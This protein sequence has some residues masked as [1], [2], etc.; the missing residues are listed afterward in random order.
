MDVERGVS[1]I[2]QQWCFDVRLAGTFWKER[3]A[4]LEYSLSSG[5]RTRTS[6]LQNHKQCDIRAIP[7]DHANLNFISNFD[8]DPE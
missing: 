5:A 4:F 2:E 1:D 3:Q 8:K 7:S 6:T